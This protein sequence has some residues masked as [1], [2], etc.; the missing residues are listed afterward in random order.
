MNNLRR[1]IGAGARLL[2]V[3]DGQLKPTT[4]ETPMI[5]IETIGSELQ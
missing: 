3:A 2:S 1:A 5:A 4:A